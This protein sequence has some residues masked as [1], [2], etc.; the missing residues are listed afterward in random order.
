MQPTTPIGSRTTSELPTVCSQVKSPA[1]WAAVRNEFSG[2]PT[3]TSWEN[4][5]GMPTSWVMRSASASVR[6]A[7]ASPTAVSSAVLSATGVA[8]HDG[9]AAR[10]AATAR[11]TSAI[12]P[13]GTVPM[14]C[15]VV[16]SMTAMVPDTEDGTHSPPMYNVSRTTVSNGS[17]ILPLSCGV[18]RVSPGAGLR[19]PMRPL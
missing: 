4:S 17:M 16:E 2:R 13:S 19:P 15:S 14:T 12:D 3:W 11:S 1:T 9:K 7:S 5:R 6:S 8:D 10:A 18:G